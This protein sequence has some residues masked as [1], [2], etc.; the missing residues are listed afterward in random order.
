MDLILLKDGYIY[1]RATRHYGSR[2]GLSMR[3]KEQK[4]DYMH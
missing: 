2:K 3:R 1:N 4:I